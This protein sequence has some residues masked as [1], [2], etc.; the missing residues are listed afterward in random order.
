MSNLRAI[1]IEYLAKQCVLANM[2]RY[3]SD[4]F[5]EVSAVVSLNVMLTQ[6]CA[7]IRNRSVT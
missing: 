7:W 2:F 1:E 3:T 5:E 6:H 4:L